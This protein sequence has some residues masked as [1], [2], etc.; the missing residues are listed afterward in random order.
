MCVIIFHFFFKIRVVSIEC[1]ET[2]TSG[3]S[4]ITQAIQQT[5]QISKQ[6]HVADAK[7]GKTSACEP[8]LVL[9]VLLIGWQSGASFLSQSLGVVMQNQTSAKDFWQLS[10]DRSIGVKILD[11]SFCICSVN[12]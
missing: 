3:R 6:I 10:E 4:Q 5:H 8:R 12:V 2:K 9:F 1:R 7:R 11:S